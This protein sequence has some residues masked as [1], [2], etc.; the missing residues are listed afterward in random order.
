M[1]FSLRKLMIG[2]SSL[3]VFSGW[4]PNILSAPKLMLSPP[5]GTFDIFWIIIGRDCLHN[6]QIFVES[7]LGI[8][9]SRSCCLG[10]LKYLTSNPL[11]HH[12]EVPVISLQIIFTPKAK[13][14]SLGAL[15]PSPPLSWA[16]ITCFQLTKL[17]LLLSFF[18]PCHRNWWRETSNLWW[19]MACSWYKEKR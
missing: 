18:P 3:W 2:L 14:K 8:L 16:Y 9:E 7:L 1:P 6:F 13:F 4:H 17:N 15:M 19:K 10:E 12:T 11:F 5:P